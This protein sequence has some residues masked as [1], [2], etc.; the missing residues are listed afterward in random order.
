MPSRRDIVCAPVP[1]PPHRRVPKVGISLDRTRWRRKGGG[2]DGNN[3]DDGPTHDLTAD[4]VIFD[5]RFTQYPEGLQ[6]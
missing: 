6:Q 1:L 4:I 5:G 2:D 3:G